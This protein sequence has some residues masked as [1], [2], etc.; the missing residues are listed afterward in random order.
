MLQASLVANAAVA[1][2]LGDR[3]FPVYAREPG[4]PCALLTRTGY[5]RE[6][7]MAGYTGKVTATFRID[8]AAKSFAEVE[9]A[10]A[11]VASHL[12]TL[13]KHGGPP[14]RRVHF[15]RIDDASDSYE[16]EADLYTIAIVLVIAFQE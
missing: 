5:E 4:F 15:A 6:R 16:A 3:V 11:A 9:A 12:D 1:A 2:V 13:D 14:F 7:N 8:L 10:E